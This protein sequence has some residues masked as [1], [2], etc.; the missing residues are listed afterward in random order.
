MQK[1]VSVLPLQKIMYVTFICLIFSGCNQAFNTAGA[2]YLKLGLKKACFEEDPACV[3]AVNDQFDACH[4][5][6][7]KK[8]D[9]YMNSSTSDEDELLK[10]YSEKM[11]SCIVDDNGNPY[12]LF[13][14]E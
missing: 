5:K 4:E 8:W 7:E 3:A 11:Y 14:P 1:G 9:A 12:F 6:Y 10:L 13:E 2:Q